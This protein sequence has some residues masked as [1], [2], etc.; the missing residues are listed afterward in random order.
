VFVTK[1]SAPAGEASSSNVTVAARDF[2]PGTRSETSEAPAK[3]K[4]KPRKKTDLWRLNNQLAQKRFRQK[5]KVCLLKKT[6][7]QQSKLFI[8]PFCA[9][10]AFL[11]GGK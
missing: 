6:R 3:P 8:L 1:K 4:K 5:Q 11:Q 10:R 7:L 9:Y 2:E